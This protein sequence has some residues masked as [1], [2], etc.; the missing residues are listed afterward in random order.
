MAATICSAVSGSDRTRTPIALQSAL[1][2]AAV[3][4]P[5]THSPT[6]SGGLRYDDI[7]DDHTGP[8]GNIR[9]LGN[10]V[11]RLGDRR[12]RGRRRLAAGSRLVT[13][14]AARGERSRGQYDTGTA[15]HVLSGQANIVKRHG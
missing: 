11:A 13:A 10:R 7:A 9:C 3:T 1:P 12:R 8:D 6:P 15:N 14:T 5:C 4:G 2:M